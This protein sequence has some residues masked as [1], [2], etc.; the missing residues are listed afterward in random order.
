MTGRPLVRISSG[1]VDVQDRVARRRAAETGDFG[2]EIAASEDAQ[3]VGALLAVDL[4][5]DPR[6]DVRGDAFV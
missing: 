4:F 5:H 1:Q 2:V 6:F 3:H